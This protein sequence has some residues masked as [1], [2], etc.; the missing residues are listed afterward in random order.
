[1]NW[2]LC[3]VGP[4]L[5]NIVV[6]FLL[7]KHSKHCICEMLVQVPLDTNK[8]VIALQLSDSSANIEGPCIVLIKLIVKFCKQ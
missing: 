2:H 5:E 3:P 1:M 6:E 7:T 8:R 4:V